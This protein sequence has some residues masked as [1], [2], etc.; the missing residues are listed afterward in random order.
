MPW[1]Q[2]VRFT[3]DQFLLDGPIC[4]DFRKVRSPRSEQGAD[5]LVSRLAERTGTT[6]VGSNCKRKLILEIDMPLQLSFKMD[7]SYSL[8][9]HEDSIVL[10]ARTDVGAIRG[11]STIYQL[12]ERQEGAQFIKGAIINDSPRFPWRGLLIDVCRHF[13]PKEMIMRQLDCMELV[14]MN[15][16]HLHLTE[17]QRFGIESST[18][19]R[20]H[21]KGSGGKFLSKADIRDIIREADSRGIRVIPEFDMPGHTTSWFVGHPEL[22]SAPGPYSMETG[23]GVFDPTM[24]PTKESTYK[25]LDAF[26]AEMAELFP[27][28]FMHIGGDENNGVQWSANDQIQRFMQD[29]GLADNHA[30]QA[31]FNARL[32]KILNNYGKRMVGWDEIISDELP[33]DIVI[34]SWRGKEGLI[35]AAKSGKYA[36]LS[37]GY[38]ID[39]CRST[40]HHYL[41]D[42]LTADMGLSPSEEQFILGGEATMWSEL[43]DDRTVDSRIWP[44]TAAIAERL[45]S[46]ADVNYVPEMYERLDDIT[47]QLDAIGSHVISGQENLL[48]LLSGGGSTANLRSR[49]QILQP[50]KDY[51]RHAMV[52]H[53]VHTPLTNLADVAVPDPPYARR[54]GKLITDHFSTRTRLTSDAVLNELRSL[55]TALRDI[56]DAQGLPDIPHII[57]LLDWAT[58]AIHVVNGGDPWNEQDLK[59]LD[60]LLQNARAPFAECELALIDSFDQLFKEAIQKSQ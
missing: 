26:F 35:N 29:R 42:P 45:W 53:S 41:N 55:R 51:Q 31:Y 12:F 59:H 30:L 49:V 27:D 21:E 8:T 1:P 28:K 11:L 25:F 18:F 52:P 47:L 50:V 14:K 15:V 36:I 38:Y 39:L 43:V 48:R 60:L 22:A 33:N 2:D 44:R 58:E 57:E 10:K 23:F 54:I 7:E 46:P 13:M 16:L 5:R 4:I 9:V 3:S 24:D 56:P 20:L 34:Q 32:N 6:L 40:E 17:D 37:N 19:P